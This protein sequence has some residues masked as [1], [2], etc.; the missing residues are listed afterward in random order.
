[1]IGRNTEINHRKSAQLLFSFLNHKICF[2]T[3]LT[4]SLDFS[5]DFQILQFFVEKGFH[6]CLY[7]TSVGVKGWPGLSARHRDHR[8]EGRKVVRS[9]ELGGA[10]WKS[11]IWI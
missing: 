4:A 5:R 2:G 9:G 1:M 10:L 6:T 8:D 11:V 7:L 3:K